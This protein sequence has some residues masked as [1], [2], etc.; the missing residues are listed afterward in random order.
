MFLLDTDNVSIL[1]RKTQPAYGRLS[2]RMATHLT[3]VFYYSIVSFH[4]QVLGAH[5]YIRKAKSSTDLTRGYG[6]LEMVL[7]EFRKA[8]VLP[9]DTAAATEFASLRALKV[10]IGTMDLRIASIALSRSMTVLSRNLRDF[11]QV[12]GLIVEDWTA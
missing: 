4:E 1:Q 10:R 12:P 3:T 5:L 11:T 2:S 8:Q 6:S 9:F 7:T